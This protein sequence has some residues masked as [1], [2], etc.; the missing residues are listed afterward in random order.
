[1]EVER[2][3][4]NMY[5]ARKETYEEKKDALSD[6]QSKLSTLQTTVKQLSD[7]GELRAYNVT[8]SDEDKITAEATHNAFEG[9]HSVEV[10]QLAAS[11][12]WVHTTGLE[13][14]E[15]YVKAGTFIYSYNHKETVITTTDDTTLED[16]V[17][18]INNDADNPGVTAGLLYYNDMYHLVLSGNDAGTDYEISINASST[19]VW[20]MKSTFAVDGDNAT[21]STK[22]TELDQFSG[23]LGSAEP[24]KAVI[25]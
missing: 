14:V 24:T 7:A 22:I 12:R 9:N 19:E 11:E 18:L 1:M 20:Q 2:R 17:G 8:S 15:D 16:L 13:Y 25:L 5:T 21:L 6:L 23:T 4:L 3:T 10:N